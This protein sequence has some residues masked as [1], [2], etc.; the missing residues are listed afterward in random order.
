MAAACVAGD[1]TSLLALLQALPVTPHP[2]PLGFVLFG[3]SSERPPLSRTKKALRGHRA[4]TRARAPRRQHAV[5]KDSPEQKQMMFPD[6]PLDS[7][8]LPGSGLEARSLAE[9]GP[10]PARRAA[11]GV[12]AR[13]A[14]RPALEQI[15][16]SRRAGPSRSEQAGELL[17]EPPEVSGGGRRPGGGRWLSSIETLCRLARWLAY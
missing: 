16:T 14:S 15:R 3:A 11:I 8:G 17:P 12:P 7:A 4:L 13:A 6:F 1:P 2:Q 9:G 5:A 10:K